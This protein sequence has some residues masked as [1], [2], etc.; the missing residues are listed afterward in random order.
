MKLINQKLNP[1]ESNQVNELT[2]VQ[3]QWNLSTE[4]TA[5]NNQEYQPESLRSKNLWRLNTEIN[6]Q[7]RNQ[8]CANV[9]TSS[10]TVFF[11]LMDTLIIV[12]VIVVFI[13][14]LQVMRRFRPH[15]SMYKRPS[16]IDSMI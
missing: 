12:G 13:T 10:A 1:S 15:N 7:A 11:P 6:Q 8:E 9:S 16:S 3:D 4:T 5:T 14:T 2:D